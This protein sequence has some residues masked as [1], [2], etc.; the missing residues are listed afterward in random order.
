MLRF[1]VFI[2]C[3][4]IIRKANFTARQVLWVHFLAFISG[5]LEAVYGNVF[6]VFAEQ[7][8]VKGF[9]ARRVKRFDHGL[10]TCFCYS[11]SF[12]IDAF[13]YAAVLS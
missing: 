10:L 4:V 7:S 6:H 1:F 8:A 13:I 9:P 5:S 3:Y 11:L 2:Q 12:F